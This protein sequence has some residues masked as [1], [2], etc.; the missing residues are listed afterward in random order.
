MHCGL[1]F[2]SAVVVVSVGTLT[3]PSGVTNGQHSKCETV[4][5]CGIVI[6][7]KRSFASLAFHY[8]VCHEL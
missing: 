1:K 7:S 6:Q 2:G 3:V 8:P 4:K 5:S